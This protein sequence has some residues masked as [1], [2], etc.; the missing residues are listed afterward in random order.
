M[1]N[2]LKVHSTH[3]A[4]LWSWSWLFSL[5]LA[6]ANNTMS[7][8][9][10]ATC[11]PQQRSGSSFE[12]D[13]RAGSRSEGLCSFTSYL[14]D[15]RVHSH[16]SFNKL[17]VT[18]GGMGQAESRWEVSF[19]ALNCS[20]PYPCHNPKTGLIS[21]L[22]EYPPTP[23]GTTVSLKGIHVPFLLADL[24]QLLETLETSVWSQGGGLFTVA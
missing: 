9:V 7:L 8:V 19:S 24:I 1:Q 10:P 6:R 17:L 16:W 4:P 5:S 20:F 11:G 18:G 21:V 14:L 15:M 3:P 22:Y 12:R 2:L 13:Y 23:T